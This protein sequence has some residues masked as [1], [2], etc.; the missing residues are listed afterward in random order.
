MSNF[1]QGSKSKAISDRSGM[2]FPYREMRKEW[3]GSLVHISE[4]EEKHPQLE[5]KVQKGDA[6]GLQNARPDRTE[7]PVAHILTSNAFSSGARDTIIVNVNDPGHGFVNGDVVRFRGTESK[8]PEYPQVSRLEAHDVNVAQGHIVTKID[9]DNFSFSPNDT[10]DKFLT[11]NCTPG[12]TTVYVDMDGV[13][14]EYYQAVATYATSVGLL[15]SGGDWYDMS[16]SIELAA[17]NAAPSTYF[18]NLAKRAEADALVDLVIAKN[19]TWDVLSTGPT[20]NAQ[21]T[22]WITANY[23]TPGSGVGRAPATVN[24]ATNFNKGP[25]GGPNKLLIDDRTEYINQFETAGGKGFKYYESGG[26]LKFGGDRASVGPVTLL[27]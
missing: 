12:V 27:A 5:P 1:A 4:F 17:I 14:T 15:E 26:I 2:E 7:P 6:Q 19:N 9:N 16:P 8:F 13:L 22:A 11:D 24:Y 20:Y 10:L 21:K 25:Y 18:Q 3:N 23:G